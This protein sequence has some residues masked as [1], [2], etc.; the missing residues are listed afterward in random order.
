MDSSDFTI[1]EKVM[2]KFNVFFEKRFKF[3]KRSL[4]P[5]KSV[6]VYIFTITAI[7]DKKKV[8]INEVLK[9]VCTLKRFDKDHY[10]NSW[11]CIMLVRG[12]LKIQNKLHLV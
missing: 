2:T 1:H 4:T 5:K 3:G 10:F 9:A 7:C 12:S 6:P 11:C 8:Y